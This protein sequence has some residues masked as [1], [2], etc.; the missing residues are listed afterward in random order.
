[1][2]N[3]GRHL[4][5]F[6]DEIIGELYFVVVEPEPLTVERIAAIKSDPKASKA[7]RI[8]IG[9]KKCPSQLK[10]YS[11]LE[12]SKSLEKEGF[13]VNTSAPDEFTC[14]CASTKIDAKILKRNLHALLGNRAREGEEM[15]Y[16]KMYERSVLER[17]RSEFCKLLAGNP[18]EEKIQKFIEQN[19]VLLHQFV[20]SSD[21]RIVFKPKFSTKYIGDFAFATPQ[22]ELVVIEIEPL[23][24]LVKKDGHPTAELNHAFGQVRDWLHEIN[25]HKVAVLDGLGVKREKVGKVR[26]VVIAGRDAGHDENNLR[27]IKGT[28]HGQVSFLTYDDIL[29]SMDTLISS[30]EKV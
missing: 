19:P 18:K 21:D 10:L 8:T 12:T 23:I 30:I 5:T 24:K 3:P 1:V 22:K 26:G 20:P 4:I 28:D 25:E 13:I 27:K 17:I 11:A 14:E 15:S 29:A 9:C 6:G 2:Y 7:V 16:V